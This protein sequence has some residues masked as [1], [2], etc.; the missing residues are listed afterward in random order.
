M[1]EVAAPKNSK[2]DPESFASFKAFF[3]EFA[4]ESDRACVILGAAKIDI[5]LKQLL[6]R[7]FLP[8]TSNTDEL[9]DGDSALGTFSAKI[10]LAYRLGLLDAEFTRALNLIRKIRNEFAHEASTV[11][12]SHPSHRDRIKH[13]V[14]SLK[15]TKAFNSF[16][17][18]TLLD[19]TEGSARDFR[20]ALA[21][22]CARLENAIDRVSQIDESRCTAFVPKAWLE[23]TDES[24]SPLAKQT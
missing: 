5:L 15:S 14:S 20:A 8:S 12:L 19:H 9:L 23:E 17:N 7:L 6:L 1:T 16:R 21:L 18:L 24:E 10:Q 2:T 22:I 3:L 4:K 11:S 13:L